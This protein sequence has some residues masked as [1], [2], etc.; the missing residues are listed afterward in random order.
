M[1]AYKR[2]ASLKPGPT[3]N[4]NRMTIEWEGH[5]YSLN[6]TALN[7]YATAGELKAA[8]D[9]FTQQNFGYVLTD[10]WFHKNRN[11]RW[12]V[13]TGLTPPSVWPE[14]EPIV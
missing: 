11:G 9:K 7:K 3:G 1:T 10:V 14:D 13:A 6:Q 5:S 8:L 2:I 4:T 12:A